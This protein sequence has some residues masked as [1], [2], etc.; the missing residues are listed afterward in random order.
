MRDKREVLKQY[1]G[2]DSFRPGQEQVVDAL[3]EGKDALAV[4]PTGAGKSICFQVPAL[5]MDGITLVISPLLSLMKDQVMTLVANGVAG[6]YLNSSLTERQYEKAVENAKAGKYKIIYVAPERLLTPRFLSFALS[7]PISMVAVDE[8][9]CVSQWGQDFRPS[10]LDIAEFIGRLPRRPVVGAFTATATPKVKA[11]ILQLLQLNHPLTLGLGFDR[12][13]LFFR[14]MEPKDKRAALW[15]FL[16]EQEGK[17]GIIYCATRKTVEELCAFL[18]EKGRKAVAYH[19]GMDHQQR[20]KN[21]EDFLYDRVP[22]MVATNAF[23]M[24]IDK[25][26]VRFVVHY[27]MPKDVESYYQEA[28]RAGRD[29]QKAQCLLLYAKKDVMVQQFLIRN[30]KDNDRLSDEEKAKVQ[31]AD[32]ER[33]KQMTWYCKTKE[34][35][36]RYLLRY[37]DE[38]APK[39][40]PSCGNCLGYARKEETDYVS[41]ERFF[42]RVVESFWDE[43]GF[44]ARRSKKKNTSWKDHP[45]FEQL[46][47]VRKQLAER[48][49][50]PAFVVFS[51]ATLEEMVEKMPR[52]EKQLLRISGVGQKKMELYGKAFLDAI[53]DYCD[54]C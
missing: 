37:F 15:D 11:D 21:Q 46:K 10:Y 36:R 43:D 12:P 44:L 54:Q 2:Y 40:C 3:L 52:T 30:N 20:A 5:L 35:L 41:E 1:F 38:A 17:S 4:M 29:G 53:A 33:L 7:A 42:S 31:M 45:L 18:Q 8:A 51:D 26:N 49:G 14:V 13:N 50:V 39:T 24:G 48:S 32:E 34:C 47:Q 9:H 22:L 28:G 23:G 25:P 16:E 6:A 27:Q 19:G